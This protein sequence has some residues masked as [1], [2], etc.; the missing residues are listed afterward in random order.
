MLAFNKEV[1]SERTPKQEKE[2]QERVM[3][4]IKQIEKAEEK[5]NFP[6][7]VTALCNYCGFKSQCPSFKH[8]VKVEEKSI[9]E[10]KKD[11]GVKLVDE[12]SETKVKLVELK[13]KEEEFREKLITYAK[14]FGIDIVYGSNNKCF[15][16]EF[17]KIVLPEDEEEK[18]KL[19][20][21]MKD[22]G[23]YEE[24][25]MVCYPK[26]N[27]KVIKGEID[28]RVKKMLEIIKDWRLSLS[29]RKDVEEE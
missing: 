27:S 5:D 13:E 17:D 10:F 1:I 3:K 22:L 15:I 4:L 2:L 7:N 25:S 6:T 24:C 11:E 18:V 21:L 19:I 9:K 12:Y 20:K 28:K 14:Q 16:K 8:L 29:K 26:L 23:V